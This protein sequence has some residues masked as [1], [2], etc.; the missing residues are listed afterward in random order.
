PSIA[1]LYED[2]FNY[3]S[4]MCLLRMREA[5]M[6]MIGAAKQRGCRVVVAGSDA[7]DRP[8]PYL[9]AGADAVIIGEGERTLVELLANW[10]HRDE[11]DG[12]AL[13]VA[14]GVERT[15]PR[16]VIRNLDDL[17]LPAWDLVDIERYRGIWE[18]RHGRFSLN[19]VTSRGCPFHCNWSAKPIW[20]QRYHARSPGIVVEELQL[21]RDSFGAEHIWFMDDIVGIKPGWLQR[22]AGLV[23][24]QGLRTPFKCLSRVDLL[25][26]PG[27]IEA[28]RRAGCESVWTGVESGSPEVL[29]AMDKGIRVEQVRE[30]TRRLH[31]AGSE[32]GFCIQLG[33]LGETREDIE[34]TFALVRECNPDRIG[35]SVSYPLP[36]TP[37]FDRVRDQLGA[38]QNWTDSDDLAMMYRGAFGTE[39]YRRL[40][41]T[42]HKEFRMRKASARLREYFAKRETRL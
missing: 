3:L 33:Y 7:S 41:S 24:E 39:V 2:N 1:I 11:V 37:F 21:L 42:L 10:A 27:E 34:A 35:V 15:P 20:C 26:R 18:R 36:G 30:A 17:P 25:L 28:L 9:T 8:E 5:A 32:V 19:I 4:K 13:P 22:F 12:L 23:E 40:H 16:A 6:R 31:E 29:D 14:G 38:K